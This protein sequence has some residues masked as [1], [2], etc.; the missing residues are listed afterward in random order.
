MPS[1]LNRDVLVQKR[2]KDQT[3]EK[4]SSFFFELLFLIITKIE[5]DLKN[6]GTPFLT[7]GRGGFLDPPKYA[8]QVQLVFRGLS[9][10]FL[11]SKKIGNPRF[12]GG[13]HHKNGIFR[14]GSSTTDLN[15]Q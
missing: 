4:S 8:L 7:T 9:E 1:E 13:F 11:G 5:L 12:G 2:L 15:L 6:G 10:H 14:N 3:L